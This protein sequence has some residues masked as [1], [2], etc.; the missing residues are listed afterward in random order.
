MKKKLI[1][2]SL[3]MGNPKKALQETE[4]VLKKNPKLQCAQALK[5]LSYLRLGKEDESQNILSTLEDISEHDEATLQ[6]MTFVYKET[7]QC[8]LT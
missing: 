4:K 7:E 8:I 5:A 3:E 1:L 6:V 2:D